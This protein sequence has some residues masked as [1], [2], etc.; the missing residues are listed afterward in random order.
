MKKGNGS[1]F[2]GRRFK[3]GAYTSVITVIVLVIV[4]VLNVLAGKFNIKHDITTSGLYTLTEETEAVLNG[5]TD[6]INIYYLATEGAQ[7]ETIYKMVNC[8]ADGSSKIK[9]LMRDPNL[10]PNFIYNYVEK[11]TS[12]YSDSVIVENA[13][14]GKAK[15]VSS[16]DFREYQTD[17]QNQ[18]S[19]LTGYD[20]EGKIDSA[21]Q[22]VTSTEAPKVYFTTGHGEVVPQTGSSALKL[23]DKLNIGAGSVSLIEKNEI[24][25]DCSA[26]VVAG[27]QSDFTKDET[28]LIKDY[29]KNGGKAIIYYD[30]S[31][32]E[33]P[34]VKSVL[35]EYGV[36]PVEGIVLEQDADHMYQNVPLYVCPD[37][38]STDVTTSS[39]NKYVVAV[40]TIGLDIT[41]EIRGSVKRTALMNT[42]DKAFS[43]ID[44]TTGSYGMSDGD[45]AGP[46]SLGVLAEENYNDVKTKLIVFGGSNLIMEDVMAFSAYGNSALFTDAL[47][48]VVDRKD[49]VISIP[50]KSVVEENLVV[51]GRDRLVLGILFIL[52]IPVVTIAA[53]VFVVIKRRRR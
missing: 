45:I 52:A 23:I 53:G 35:A 10:Y 15:L 44:V 12:V 28:Q 36:N 3:N 21:I 22:Y 39:V 33:L 14:T 1:S 18:T 13:T 47:N 42:S 2:S 11:G 26:L 17:Y 41:S 40:Q 7:D 25:E 32:N 24:P 8:F 49:P 16:R 4:V 51:P 46:F 30:Y 43:K 20:V 6:D 48:Y 38:L 19:T 37:V 29:L 5:L 31:Q 27:P 9:V 34:N 50:V